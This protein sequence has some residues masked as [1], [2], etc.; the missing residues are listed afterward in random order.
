MTPTDRS[1]PIDL[2]DALA[3]SELNFRTFFDSI[4]DLLFVL[5]IEGN[6][7]KVNRTVI[8]RLGYAEDELL[9]RH[10]LM[11]HPEA[12]REEAGAIVGAMLAGTEQF[13]PC[14]CSAATGRSSPWRPAWCRACGTAGR[15]CSA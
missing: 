14:P 4:D 13:C 11:V 15:R 7:I 1:A 9:G 12:R 5:D 8:D 6:I 2:R 3:A 10:V